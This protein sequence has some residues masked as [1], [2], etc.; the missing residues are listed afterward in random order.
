MAIQ[1]L[2][3]W[4]EIDEEEVNTIIGGNYNARTGREGGMVRMEGKVEGEKGGRNSKDKKREGKRLVK[5]LEEKEWGI[6]NGSMRGDE[7]EEFTFTGGKDNSVIDFVI[8]NREVRERVEE[9]QIGDRVDSDHHPI[10][11]KIK[12]MIVGRRE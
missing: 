5:F 12:G 7:K 1:K 3:K 6:F 2:E 4:T 10:E 11:V 9:L 8:D